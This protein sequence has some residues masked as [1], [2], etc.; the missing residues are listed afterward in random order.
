MGVDGVIIPDLIPEEAGELLRAS[1]EVGLSTVFLLAPTSGIDR[2]KLVASVS[3]GFI[4]YVSITGVTGAQLRLDNKISNSINSIRGVTN[5]PI[6]I[7]FGISNPQEASIVAQLCD[8]VVVGSAIV[9]RIGAGEPIGDF[10]RFLR[11]V[12]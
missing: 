7:G 6:V 10:V 5:T 4:Y 3:K 12:V 9:R 2:I 8:G 1:E 11:E